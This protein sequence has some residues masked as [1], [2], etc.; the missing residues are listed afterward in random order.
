MSHVGLS[1]N[2]QDPGSGRKRSPSSGRGRNFTAIATSL[3]VLVGIVGGAVLAVV[4]IWNHL[5]EPPPDYPGPG[6]AEVLVHVDPGQSVTAI[7][8]TLAE[9]DVVASSEA[10]VNA[11]RQDSRA[12]TITPGGY[13]MQ[14]QMS[15]ADAFERFF[16][17]EARYEVT[18]AL[19]EGLWYSEVAARTAAATGKGE[20]AYIKAMAD[21]DQVVLPDWSPA[22]ESGDPRRAEGFLYPATYPIPLGDSAAD[23]IQTYVD[24]FD[25]T[26][27]QVGLTDAPDKVGVSPYEALIIASLIQ[28]EGL[29]QDFA[30]VS[31]VIYNRL[32]PATWGDTGGLLQIDA[33]LNYG[34]GEKKARLSGR[35]LRTDGPY[36]T[37]TRPGL[38]PT[39]INSPG[40]EALEA[41][42]NPAD[43]DW[44]YYVTVDLDSGETRFSESYEEFLANKDQLNR[45]CNDNPGKC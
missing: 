37:Y 29:P 12:E 14:A 22:G 27:A 1:M 32:D 16:D 10:F 23:T 43:G 39:P 33:T 34:L 4:L 6:G 36:N 13:I 42:L 24:R 31:R 3:L 45:W 11:A 25:S 7:G 38:P 44:L 20:R 30:K 40:K 17:P 18:V 41:A 35:Q 15:A 9:A 5:N 2:E 21:A 26:A 19:P 28:A 8:N